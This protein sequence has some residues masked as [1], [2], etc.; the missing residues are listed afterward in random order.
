MRRASLIALAVALA[1]AGCGGQKRTIP[2]SRAESML[3]QLDTIGTEFDKGACSTARDRVVSLE[4][5]ARA[6]PSSVDPEVKRNLVSGL[7][8]LQ[9]LVVSDCSRPTPTNPTTTPTN[10]A[11]TTT[12]PTQTLP[13]TPTQTTPTTPTTP[14][15]TTPTTPT[16]TGGGGGVTVPG[17]T[18]ASGAQ[19]QPGSARG[20]PGTGGGGQ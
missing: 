8:R 20:G 3:T 9:S 15:Q 6:L 7:R 19:V 5:R 12:T 2:T 11:P 14:T 13:T 1:V 17:T 4:A 18:G 10:T 16:T